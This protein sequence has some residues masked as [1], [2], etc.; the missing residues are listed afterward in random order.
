MQKYSGAVLSHLGDLLDADRVN[1]QVSIS[2][3]DLL[4]WCL[5]AQEQA[6]GVRYARHRHRAHWLQRDVLVAYERAGYVPM[7][8]KY[9]VAGLRDAVGQMQ[10]AT[11][12]RVVPSETFSIS[13]EIPLEP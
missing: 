10:R 1:K 8:R 6:D 12:V 4:G 7:D 2:A 5:V 13:D 3:G 11:I 9:F